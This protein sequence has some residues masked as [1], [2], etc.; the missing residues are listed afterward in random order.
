MKRLLKLSIFSLIIQVVTIGQT[1]NIDPN[2]T[3]STYKCLSCQ[4]TI[5]KY[6][7]EYGIEDL[8]TKV[9][10]NGDFEVRLWNSVSNGTDAVLIKK[11]NEAMS[12]Y[13]L[14][15]LLN[16]YDRILNLIGLY[17]P[18]IVLIDSNSINTERI[19][20]ELLGNDIL[21]LPDEKD[22][23]DSYTILDGSLYIVEICN[24]VG[25]R[26]YHYIDP[27]LYEVAEA[28]KMTRIIEI[29]NNEIRLK[30]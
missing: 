8:Q 5:K 29:L 17:S 20:T 2:S 16:T 7:I 28:K 27:K 26:C 24:N 11:E 3:D 14:D 13:Y 12:I 18:N 22:I 4:K 1:Q 23:I 30:Y 10:N 9:F 21:N 15:D 6:T 25:Y 19:W